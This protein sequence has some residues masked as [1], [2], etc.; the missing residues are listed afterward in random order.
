[1]VIRRS[2]LDNVS[3]T[4]KETQLFDDL[5]M[6][7]CDKHKVQSSESPDDTLEL[8]GRPSSRFR[9]SS[10]KN[11]RV[12]RYVISNKRYCILPGASPGSR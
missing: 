11:T 1:M 4:G 7:D 3:P 5:F 2:N 10:C 6:I 9:C 8:P 12:K